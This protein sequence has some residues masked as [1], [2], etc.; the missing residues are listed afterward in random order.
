MNPRHGPPEYD[1]G[2][3]IASQ[4]AAHIINTDQPPQPADSPQR[5]SGEDGPWISGYEAA[6]RHLLGKG[7]T[8]APDA[9]GLAAMRR[10]GGRAAAAA[11]VIAARWEPEG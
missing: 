10:Q 4:D 11:R 9:L 6:A 3:P 2:A 1:D 8:P 7:L 5:S